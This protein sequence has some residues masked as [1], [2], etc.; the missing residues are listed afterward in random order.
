MSKEKNYSIIT[1]NMMAMQVA[2]ESGNKE[3]F[4]K[5][6]NEQQLQNSNCVC[7]DTYLSQ[8]L[9]KIYSQ[10]IEKFILK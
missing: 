5:L 3:E 10:A 2:I 8:A 4:R 1:R 9:I 6:M 7:G